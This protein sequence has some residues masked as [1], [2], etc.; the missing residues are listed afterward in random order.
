MKLTYPW[1][2][3]VLEWDPATVQSLT[4]E[5]PGLLY[6]FLCDLQSQTNGMDGEVLVSEKE[7]PIPISKR[8]ELLTD[9]IGWDGNNRKVVSKLVGILDKASAEDPFLQ[10]RNGFLLGLEKYI[11]GLADSQDISV[12]LDNLSMAALLKA[13]G[14]RV[15]LEYDSLGDRLFAYFDFVTR[16]EGEKLFVLYGL[17]AVMAA[18]ELDLFLQTALQHGMRILLVD[19]IGYPLLKCEKRTTIDS[20]LCV[21]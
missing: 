10:E 21:I 8:V 13:V 16:C 2:H 1:F 3:K 4:I 9:F 18:E 5:C 19:A 15:D 12:R 17:R 7:S 11:Y 14:L 20:D 6:R